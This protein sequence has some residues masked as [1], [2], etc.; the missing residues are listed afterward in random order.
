MNTLN[1]K[2]YGDIE[3]LKKDIK[4]ITEVLDRQ[5]AS[6][7]IDVIS[8]YSGNVANMFKLSE[9]ERTRLIDARVN[10]LK[11]ALLERL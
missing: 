9:H 3:N 7:L 6:L 1:L 4:A 5:G 10:E 8:E 2:E 11:Q